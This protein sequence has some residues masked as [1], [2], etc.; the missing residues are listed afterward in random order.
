MKN[1]LLISIYIGFA[2]HICTVAHA[3]GQFVVRSPEVFSDQIEC[4]EIN[5]VGLEIENNSLQ[6]NYSARNICNNAISDFY[7]ETE[8]YSCTGSLI[9]DTFGEHQKRDFSEFTVYVDNILIQMQQSFSAQINDIDVTAHILQY[10]IGYEQCGKFELEATEENI[11]AYKEL[12]DRDILFI[13]DDEIILP[14]WDM[15]KVYLWQVEFEKNKDV[16][17]KISYNIL[18]GMGFAASLETLTNY[19]L[20]DPLLSGLPYI[21]YFT[22]TIKL[23]GIEQDDMARLSYAII[24]LG[25]FGN[26]NKSDVT[27]RLHHDPQIFSPSALLRPSVSMS[28]NIS[29][30]SFAV[31]VYT[32]N[33]DK[34]RYVESILP[35]GKSIDLKLNDISL[36]D[37]IYVILL[38][39]SSLG[40]E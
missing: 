32:N 3:E 7:A 38:R 34:W 19:S 18:G 31:R 40:L 8:K 22:K 6:I 23:L 4:I 27:V 5:K 28:E 13:L 9:A 29:K 35:Y 11:I 20:F 17:I 37:D 36:P 16:E 10:G 21:S 39:K 2:L 25:F 14:A 26:N 24:P 15:K 30:A 33:L 1:V 12:I